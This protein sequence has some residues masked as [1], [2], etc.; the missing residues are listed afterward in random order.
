MGIIEPV[1]ANIGNSFGM[2]RISLAYK[3]R[4]GI[5]R[6]LY[7]TLQ[8]CRKMYR[9]AEPRVVLLVRKAGD[10]SGLTLHR[11][12]LG[13]DSSWRCIGG[14]DPNIMR[15]TQAQHVASAALGGPHAYAMAPNLG[16][17]SVC[18][19]EEQRKSSGRD[20]C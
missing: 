11:R 5:Q 16:S 18:C 1:F 13:G 10:V 2:R 7:G 9:H 4:L 14:S 19:A 20:S 17:V 3:K 6:K 8:N 15:S 12:S